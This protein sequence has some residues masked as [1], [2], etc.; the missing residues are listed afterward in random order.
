MPTSTF[1]VMDKDS[2]SDLS[3][4]TLADCN[5]MDGIPDIT[6]ALDISKEQS[7]ILETL[8]LEPS[9]KERQPKQNVKSGAWKFFQVYKDR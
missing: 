1:V 7:Q 8:E 2:T 3:H 6:P 5:V 4:D 9:H